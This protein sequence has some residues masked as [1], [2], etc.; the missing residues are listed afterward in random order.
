MLLTAILTALAV[1]PTVFADAVTTSAIRC[2]TSFGYTP[3]APGMQVTTWLNTS[4]TTNYFDYTITTRNVV[5][6]TPSASTLTDILTTTAVFEVTT[7]FTPEPTTI[8][9]PA[10]FLP[11]FAYDPNPTAISRAKRFDH[12]A[13]D[14]EMALAIFKRQTAAN[15][16]GGFSVDRNGSTSNIFR[17]YPQRVDCRIMFTINETVTSTVTGTPETTFAAGATALVM[18]TVTISTT[19]TVTAV[20]PR[21]TM[22]AACMGN[23]VG[24]LL[25]CTQS[26]DVGMMLNRL[27]VNSVPGMTGEDIVFNRV[28]YRPSEGFPLENEL[29]VN[30]TSAENCCIA[31][32]NTVSLIPLPPPL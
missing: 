20:A 27:L 19:T 12:Q 14:H 15:N 18:S 16:T 2:T 5:T 11:L 13:R 1:A 24:T 30:T 32:Q 21:R 28:I 29:I 3:L 9:T 23:N 31:C 22:Y 26:E 4:T 6:V 17:K 25:P 8:P 10:G 7:T